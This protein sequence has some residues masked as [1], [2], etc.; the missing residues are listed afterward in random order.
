MHVWIDDRGMTM[1][2]T[3]FLLQANTAP[4]VQP[5]ATQTSAQQRAASAPEHSFSSVYAQ[6]RAAKPEQSQQRDAAPTRHN[7]S[8]QA[9]TIKTQL[10]TPQ[11]NQIPRLQ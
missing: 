1:A 6:Q 3:D 8:T 2:I 7:A 11:R 9:T 5:G 10:Q 4:R